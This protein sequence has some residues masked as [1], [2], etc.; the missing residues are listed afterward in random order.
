MPQCDHFIYTAGKVGSTEGYQI[1]AK[2]SGITDEIISKLEK[3][4]YPLGVKTSEFEESRS[5]LILP[6]NK[7][8]YSIVKNI[9]IGYDGR[10]GTLYNHTFVIDQDDFEKLDFDSRVFEKYFIK[11]DSLRGDLNPVSLEH[12]L[13]TAD[14]KFLKKYDFV[15]LEELL[16]RISTRKKI[17]LVK[18]DELMFLHNVFAILPPPL[19][20]IPFSTLVIEPD[21]QDKFHL[22]QIPKE[23]EPKLT[24]NFVVIDPIQ[25]DISTR[26]QS[27]YDDIIKQLLQF[28]LDEDEK[29]L[30]QVFRTFE[31]IPVRLSRVRRVQ[32]EDVFIQSEFEDLSARNNFGRLKNK[33][34]KLYADKKFNESSPK[35][36]VSVTKKIRKIIQKNLKNKDLDKRKNQEIFEYVTEI[37]KT[38]LDSMY[39]LQDYSKKTLSNTVRHNISHE[40]AKLEEI[41]HKYPTPETMET[42]YVFNYVEYAKWQA[43]QFVRTVQAGIAYGLWFMGFGSKSKE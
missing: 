5:L 26:K 27:E 13:L 34:R 14:F 29:S 1:V 19:R 28:V 18:T 36:M 24:K 42:P 9:G 20:L 32:L 35:I 37:V 25:V 12:P 39:Y 8:A 23:I 43:E 38:M 15:L 40:I 11:D 16:Y 4:L 21:R 3:Y 10:R 6:H 17:A 7:I 22:I 41:M 33:V 30:Q 2:S 31:K